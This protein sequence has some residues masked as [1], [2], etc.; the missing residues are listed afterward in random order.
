MRMQIHIKNLRL[1]TIIGTDDWEREHSQDVIVNATMEFDAT[2]AVRNDEIGETVDYCAVKRRIVEQVEQ[3]R[4]LL[5][6]KLAH[7]ILEIIMEEPK[8]LK[9]SVEVDK[10]HALRFADSVSISCSAERER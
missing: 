9:A 10:P 4:F 3:A 2:E 8:V 1:R 5:V 6:E 7:R